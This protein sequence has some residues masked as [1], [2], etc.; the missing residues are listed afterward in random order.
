[1]QNYA[2]LSSAMHLKHNF[3]YIKYQNQHYNTIIRLKWFTTTP[4]WH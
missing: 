1:M 2:K 4:D 3:N